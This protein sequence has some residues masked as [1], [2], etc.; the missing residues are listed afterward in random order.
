MAEA[1][2][3]VAARPR[4]DV[5]R[6]PGVRSLGLLVGIAASV[7]VGVGVVLWMQR[8][9]YQLLYANLAE[10]DAGS[11]VQGLEGAGIP[12]RLSGDT[13]LVPADK[14]HEAR[15]KLAAQGLPQSASMGLEMMQEEKG[16][17]SSQ[18]MENARYQHALETELARTIATLQPVQAAR[19]HLAMSRPSALLRNRSP[20]SASVLVNLYP[21][22]QLEPEQVAAITHLVASSIPDLD[23]S[24]VTLIDQ[25]GQLLSAPGADDAVGRMGTQFDIVRRME[26]AYQRRIVSLLEPLAGPGKVRA[27]VN[28]AMD[29]T[30]AEEVS[31][32]FGT[33]KTALRSEQTAEDMKRGGADALGIPGSLSNQPP[34][35]VPQTPVPPPAAAAQQRNQGNAAGAPAAAAAAETTAAGNGETLSTSRRATRNYEIDRQLSRKKPSVGVLRRL[36]VAVLVDS[37]PAAGADGGDAKQAAAPAAADVD[38]MTKL[39]KEAI[40]YDEQ[41]GD[42][43]SVITA[44]F[45][46]E[47]EG[48]IPAGPPIWR[49]PALLGLLKQV[50][51]VALVALIIFTV[52]RPVAS[53]ISEPGLL[54]GPALGTELLGGQGGAGSVPGAPPLLQGMTHEQQIAAARN[55]VGQDP[56]RVAQTMRRWLEND[57]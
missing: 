28:A 1:Q 3:A 26:D 49:S 40:G 5:R 6:I 29:F 56:R 46:P 42:T 25:T 31:E 2:A 45:H 47:A 39:V 51:G 10:R 19:V 14:I 11:V 16:F 37:S 24:R 55:L 52:L 9:D 21:G 41:R 13:V 17:G 4:V 57:G 36:S 35:D 53:R 15:L 18:F 27:E 43:V 12:Y 20:A 38:R 54:G 44:A 32:T 33:D 34:E 23:A 8:P 30:E 50:F 7:A 48:A 22:R